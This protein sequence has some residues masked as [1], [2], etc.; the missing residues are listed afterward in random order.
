VNASLADVRVMTSEGQRL[1]V[2]SR[3]AIEKALGN[4]V[5]MSEQLRLASQEVL[6]NPSKLIWGP[7]RAREDK[8]LIFRAASSFAEAASQLDNAASRLEAVLKTLPAEGAP[9]ELDDAE[10]RAIYE[11]VQAAFQRFGRAEEVLWD[12]LK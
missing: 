12:Q 9:A 4:F 8:L 7:T 5:N 1:V 11:S 10:L 3:P 2:L 6:L